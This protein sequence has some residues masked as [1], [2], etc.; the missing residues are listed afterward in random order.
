[1]NGAVMWCIFG[2]MSGASQKALSRSMP[3]G[4]RAR[5]LKLA[6]TSGQRREPPPG[7]AVI[8]ATAAWMGGGGAGRGGEAGEGQLELRGDR[9]P[10]RALRRREQGEEVGHGRDGD[11]GLEVRRRLDGGLDDGGADVGAAVHADA[12]VRPGLDAGPLDQLGLVLLLARRS[13]ERRVGK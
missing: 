13:E 3:T 4:S 5:A 1:M 9:R 2:H 12:A 8:L 7:S 11:G 6:T 10:H